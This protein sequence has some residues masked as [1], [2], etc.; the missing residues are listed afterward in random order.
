MRGGLQKLIKSVAKTTC[1]AT[2]RTPLLFHRKKDVA[3]LCCLF[4]LNGNRIL[5]QRFM[6]EDLSLRAEFFLTGT[7]SF[8]SPFGNPRWCERFPTPP[9]PPRFAAEIGVCHR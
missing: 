9:S 3:K 4:L 7:F 2:T 6:P 1:Y 8:E 5:Q